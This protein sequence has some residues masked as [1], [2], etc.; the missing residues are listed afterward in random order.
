MEGITTYESSYE[1]IKMLTKDLISGQPIAINFA[2]LDT[3]SAGAIRK[4]LSE[5][6]SQRSTEVY[7]I[8]ASNQNQL[9]H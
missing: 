5:T 9:L 3:E 4:V 6:L 1:Y 8:I 7:N 2:K